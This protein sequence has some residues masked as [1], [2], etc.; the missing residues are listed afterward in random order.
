MKA[1]QPSAAGFWAGR[2]V[3]VTGATG[4]VGLHLTRLLAATGAIVTVLVRDPAKAR[5]LLPEGVRCVVAPVEDPAALGPACRGQ[6]VLFHV[7]GAVDFGEDWERFHRVNV[8][9]TRHVLAACDAAGVRRVV[10]TSSIV[11]LHGATRPVVVDETAEWNLAA[12]RVPYVTTKRQAEEVVLEAAARGRDAVVVNPASVLGPDDFTG[13]EFGTLCKRFWRGRIPLHFTGGNNFVDVR[14]VAAGHLLAAERGRAGRR[15]IL[16]GWN[17]TYGDF[18]AALARLSSRPLPRLR[19]P[20]CAAPA[21]ARLVAL[22]E[23]RRERS[24]L[25]PAQARLLGRWFWF[26]I[27]RART[28]LD[29]EPRPLRDT[30]ADTFAFWMGRPAPAA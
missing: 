15:Y 28:E 20:G 21:L 27:T 12:A 23:R 13:S 1:S 17:L 6:D 3:A 4:F 8:E 19:L 29:Y 11:A 22:C 24:Y 18:F 7:A 9:G 10:L 14:D 16:G 5:R 25:T 26:D 2:P 30:L